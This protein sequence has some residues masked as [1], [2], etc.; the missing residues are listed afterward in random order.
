MLRVP[1]GFGV[2]TPYLLVTGADA[3]LRFLAA[4]FGAREIGRS[5]APDGR[6]ANAQ[7]DFSGMTLMV[8]EASGAERIM[9]VA[10]MPCGDR[11]GGVRDPES[12]IWWIS[13]RLTDAP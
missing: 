1:P 7:M 10:A 3:Y 9:E 13:E 4:A 8:S 6:I 11:Q 12:N 5:L 2:V